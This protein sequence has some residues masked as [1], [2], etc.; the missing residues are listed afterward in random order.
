MWDKKV[1]L[2]IIL[3]LFISVIFGLITKINNPDQD[4]RRLFV[5]KTHYPKKYN[6][7]IA[8]DSRT[9]RAV[10][11]KIIADSLNG[12]AINLGY[13]SASFSKLLVNHIN[14]KITTDKSV[15]RIIIL[16]ITPLSINIDEEQNGHLQEMLNLKKEEVIDYLYFYPVKNFF[17]PRKLN[18]LFAKDTNTANFIQ[19]CHMQEGWIESDF[20]KPMPTLAL[21]SY[22]KEYKNIGKKFS[23]SILDSLCNNIRNWKKQ[24]IDVYAFFP[25]SSEKMEILEDNFFQIDRTKVVKNVIN[26]GAKWIRLDSLYYSYDGS[27]LCAKSAQTLSKEI[28]HKIKQN[29]CDSTFN[30]KQKYIANYDSSQIKAVVYNNKFGKNEFIETESQFINIEQNSAVF[31]INN[32]I[33][34]LVSYSNIFYTD[35]I[36]PIKYCIEINRN[37]QHIYYETYKPLYCLP[38]RVC[39]ARSEFVIPE[40]INLEETD[41]IKVYIHNE[42][43]SKIKLGDTFVVLR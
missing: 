1:I 40:N 12:N 2:T 32:K 10:S 28:A 35:S 39:T 31:Y 3:G 4:I 13:S 5:Y 19:K 18:L 9:Y 22:Y 30:S 21:L 8:G 6:L 15:K 14:N 37:N 29:L 25:P 17:V 26:A 36:I 42:T 24:K 41:E 43:K 16:G 7:I 11:S 34:K 27:H 33:K 20:I 23:Y 38:N